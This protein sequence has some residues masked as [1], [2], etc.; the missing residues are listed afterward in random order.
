MAETYNVYRDGSPVANG[1]TE[2]SYTDDDLT[3]STNYDYFVTTENEYGESGPSN[4]IT[5]TTDDAEEPPED[6]E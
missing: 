5:V 6:P 2:K 1:L 4:T 3:P